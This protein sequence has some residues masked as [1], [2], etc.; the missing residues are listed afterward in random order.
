MVD[1][2]PN[3][4]PSAIVPLRETDS[5][6]VDQGS[7]GVRKTSPFEAVN[8]A[9]PVATQ[10]EAVAGTDNT[11]RM[12]SLRTKQSIA[13][14]VGVTLASNAQGSKADSAVQSVNGKTGNS[15]TLAKGDIGL[16]NVDNTSDANKPISTATQT[17]LDAKANSS[18]T[19]SA[20]SGLD[21]GGSLASSR[22]IALNS[23][24]I[25]SLAKADSSVQT[26][27]GVSPT[28]GNVNVPA[29]EIRWQ[30]TRTT[31]IAEYFPSSVQFLET[32]GYS[33][34]GDGGGA[35]YKRVS[36]PAVLGGEIVTNGGFSS[37][38][39]WIKGTGWT[40]AS[41]AANKTV[42]ATQSELGQAIP[43]ISDVIYAITYT[44]SNYSGTGWV[45]PYFGYNGTNVVGTNRTANGTYTDYLKADPLN[46]RI[47]FQAQA[48]VA[49]SLDNVMIRPVIGSIQSADGAWWELSENLPDIKMFGAKGDGLSNDSPFFQGAYDFTKTKSGGAV[50]VTETSSY[51]RLVETVVFDNTIN[52]HL[53]G[54]GKPL[55]QDMST[56][57]SNTFNIGNGI[58]SNNQTIL[59]DL[60]IWGPVSPQN[61]DCIKASYAGSLRFDRV[62]IFRHKGIGINADNCWTIGANGS[63]VVECE[64][65]NVYLTGAS[66]N[67]S[68]W[69]D[70]LFNNG[71]VGKNSFNIEGTSGSLPNGPHYGTTF[72]TCRFEFNKGTGLRAD[73]AHSLNLIGCYFEFND[74]NSF[75]IGTG[76]K[77][78]NIHGNSIFTSPGLVIGADSVDIRGNCNEFNG[79]IQ[80]GDSTNVCWGPNGINNLPNTIFGTTRN[81]EYEAFPAWVS[82]SST[83][84]SS[85]AQPNLGNG[86]IIFKYKRSG[87]TVQC[88]V[89]ITMGS[90]TTYGAI[91]YG[92]R[93]P[94][95]VAA[96]ASHIGKAGYYDA[97]SD[98]TV[99]QMTAICD[100]GNN[101]VALRNDSGGV[102]G[103]AAP[104]TFASGDKIYASFTYECVS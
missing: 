58:A 50:T 52:F 56:N 20:G 71:F 38:T 24:S 62:N 70:C 7:D 78:V 97:S 90:T 32:A 68:V 13:S 29:D 11:K 59:S 39:S 25:A 36:S 75:R 96:G 91:G 57:G 8:S 55:I 80:V 34:V 18:V 79:S 54:I 82:F 85:G 30:D 33:S 67:G 1:I 27:N 5:I 89:L 99:M 35:L 31:A 48:T 15:V 72:I 47:V 73:Y 65:G 74:V 94:F 95:N 17:A 44:I 43:L 104:I 6:I 87:N 60:K 10:P 61:G 42:T 66:G 92:F 22:T 40:I 28:G 26:V 83:W 21:G 86:S 84:I 101:Y 2:R 69:T 102:V 64:L 41:G 37:D 88:S 81:M 19:I 100:P 49:C 16:G 103:P 77:G 3:A 9:A 53:M 23:T 98:A 93:L 63:S 4:L 12:T 14:E 46:G 51:Y 45:R 76:C